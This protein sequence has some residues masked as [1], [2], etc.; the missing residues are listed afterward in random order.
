MRRL[1]PLLVFIPAVSLAQDA[2]PPEVPKGTSFS[3]AFAKSTVFPGTTRTV[4]VW[5][6]AQYDGKTPACVYVNQDGLPG[7]VGPTFEKLIAAKEMPVTIA[8][9]VTP[10]EVRAGDPKAAL[11]RYN[12]SYEY[13]GLG[14]AYARMLLDELLPEVEKRTT[15]DGKPIVLS[16]RGTDRA[17]G[18]ASSGAICA[19]TAA[20]E[21]PDEFSRVFSTIGTY[22]G[23]RGGD[24][25]PTLIRKF[26][27]KPLRVYLQDGTKDL[28]IYGGDWWMANQTMERALVF[29]G[30]ETKHSWN[31]GGHNGGLA[32]GV[33]PEAMQ[34]LWK[35]WPERPKAGKGSQPLQELLIP[36][37]GWKLVG[38]GY[39]FTE[40]PA[41]SPTGDVFFNDVGSSKT[42]KVVDGKPVEW[43]ADS[44]RGD[45]QRFGP[46]GRLYA[47]AAGESKVLAWDGAGK[48]SVFAEGFKGND[49]VVLHNGAIYDTDPFETP[50]NSKVYYISP[51]GEKKVVDTGLKFANGITVSPDQTLLYVADSRTHW[52]YSYVIQPDGTLANKQKYYHLYVRDADDDSG[53][54]GLR[55]DRDGRLWVATR[56]GLQVCDQAGRVN[57]IIPTPNGKLSNLTFGGANMDVVYATCGD[58]VYSRKVKVKGSNA[59][60]PPFKPAPPRL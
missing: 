16:K 2:K 32:A 53:A 56:A 18:G 25:Y 12:R 8:I 41:T 49:L 5:V 23:L 57:S 27:P 39:K 1:L 19:F 26:E 47:N 21:R 59:F 4:T 44:K 54:D 17:I 28:N 29:A 50:N 3:F 34:F 22:V 6:P 48:P 55:C 38:E 35:D 40:G 58:K 52:V 43:L 15:K 31:D 20:W 14:D 51:K 10:G 13:D 33:F 30:Y 24:V 46:D 42:Y 9:G 36:G 37:E 7:Y 60:E 11:T 45:G